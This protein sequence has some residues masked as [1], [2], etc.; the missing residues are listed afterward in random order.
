MGVEHD[1]CPGRHAI[2]AKLSKVASLARVVQRMAHVTSGS[3]TMHGTAKARGD[4]IGDRAEE[5]AGMGR[6]HG[7]WPSGAMHGDQRKADVLIVHMGTAAPVTRSSKVMITMMVAA[8]VCIGRHSGGRN[9]AKRKRDCKYASYH[10]TF[11]PFLCRAVEGTQRERSE[12][13]GD[14][15][16]C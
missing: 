15:A 5:L 14:R 9:N 13:D 12:P 2:E 3:V 16:R 4:K 7:D 8:C 6:V 1:A 10:L 11:S